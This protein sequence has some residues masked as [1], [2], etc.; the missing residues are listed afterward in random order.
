MRNLFEHLSLWRLNFVVKS[1]TQQFKS[2]EYSVD[3]ILFEFFSDKVINSLEI[4]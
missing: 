1:I 2:I 3:F 4:G